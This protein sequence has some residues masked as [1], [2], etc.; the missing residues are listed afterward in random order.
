MEKK[1]SKEDF[2]LSFRRPPSYLA[3][4]DRIEQTPTTLN[5]DQTNYHIKAGKEVVSQF[6]WTDV[7]GHRNAITLAVSVHFIHSNMCYWNLQPPCLIGF[8]S[9]K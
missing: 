1:A 9:A 8:L 6:N 2:Q 4:V 5:L 3:L 7:L